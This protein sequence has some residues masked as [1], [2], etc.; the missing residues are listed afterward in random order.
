M[1]C[2]NSRCIEGQI[3]GK[4]FWLVSGEVLTYEYQGF[5][6]YSMFSRKPLE[7]L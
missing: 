1:S 3:R 5:E 6:D 7:R 2:F 4:V